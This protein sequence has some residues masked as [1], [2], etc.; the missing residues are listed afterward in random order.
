[1]S[2]GSL[3][4]QKD[5]WDV[6]ELELPVAGSLLNWALGSGIRSSARAAEALNTSTISP[7]TSNFLQFLL[8]V[9]S[10]NG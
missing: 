6:M 2:A 10:V 9:E 4:V 1:M 5:G 3:T 8:V 7:T